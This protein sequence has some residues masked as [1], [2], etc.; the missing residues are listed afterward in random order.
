[1]TLF[2]IRVCAMPEESIAGAG[3]LT[4]P[5]LAASDQ[6]PALYPQYRGLVSGQDYQVNAVSVECRYR[7]VKGF[8]PFSARIHD[9]LV[10]DNRNALPP[11]R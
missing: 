4:E 9:E 10:S 7:T 1:M 6:K 11:A 5:W 2:L 8:N 3:R